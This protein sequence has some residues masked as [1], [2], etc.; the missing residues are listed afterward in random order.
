MT[1][2]FFKVTS[3]ARHPSPLLTEERQQRMLL[4]RSSMQTK[5]VSLRIGH[6]TSVAATIWL[7]QFVVARQRTAKPFVKLSAPALSHYL[8][9]GSNAS[10]LAKLSCWPF[11]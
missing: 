2:S 4:R 7:P 1:S 9:Y 11:C 10:N 3:F 5:G 6:A 8:A